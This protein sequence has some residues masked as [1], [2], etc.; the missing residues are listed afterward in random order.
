MSALTIRLACVPPKTNHH[1]KRIVRIGQFSR[2]ADKPEL[3][4]AKE[5]LDN[6]L[7]PHQPAVP[8][9]A[10]YVVMLEFTWPWL[11]GH[12]AKFRAGGRQPMT[13]KPDCDNASKSLCDRLV[14]LRFIED[15]RA[16]VDLRVR[17]WWGNEPGIT[18][19]IAPF[20]AASIANTEPANWR[21]DAAKALPLLKGASL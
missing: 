15:D 5:M 18:V 21:A 20:L 10:P 4:A 17:K 11:K 14:A 2:L 12:S 13:S 19:T 8:V 3:V 16:I 6:L 1:A 9:A 7:L